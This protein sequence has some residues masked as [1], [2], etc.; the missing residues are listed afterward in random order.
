MMRRRIGRRARAGIETDTLG[1]LA[2]DIFIARF[3]HFAFGKAGNGCRYS[4]GDPMIDASERPTLRVDHQKNETLGAVRHIAPCAVRRSRRR[5][6]R[7]LAHWRC[8]W[9][10]SS[11]HFAIGKGRRFNREN[12]RRIGRRGR[13]TK[14][15]C[16]CG[17][18]TDTTGNHEFDLPFC[19][20][21]G[22]AK[23]NRDVGEQPRCVAISPR[24]APVYF[25]DF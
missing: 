19:R 18:D 17:D 8:Y 5:N 24:P 20:A 9:R 23:A 1:A 3:A 7:W 16:S 13:R 15:D 14:R 11:H 6:S 25:K 12:F 2:T 21:H 4:I 22:A 10:P